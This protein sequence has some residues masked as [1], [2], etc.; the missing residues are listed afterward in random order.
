MRI[1]QNSKIKIYWN[2]QA[3]NQTAVT[4]YNCSRGSLIR[5]Y[6]VYYGM[7]HRVLMIYFTQ[8]LPHFETTPVVLMNAP[9]ALA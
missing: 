2:V 5:K 7:Y 8:H 4:V 1:N 6:Y 3:S 9:L